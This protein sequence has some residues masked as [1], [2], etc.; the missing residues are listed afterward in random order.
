MYDPHLPAVNTEGK[1]VK[2]FTRRQLSRARRTA[3]REAKAL[4]KLE[5]R[6]VRSRA[7]R[8]ERRLAAFKDIPAESTLTL[9]GEEA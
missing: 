8:D 3:F 4:M 5:T 9:L 6:I 1:K 2:R 7:R